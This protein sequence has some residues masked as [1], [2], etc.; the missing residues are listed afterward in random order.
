MA[1]SLLA[2]RDAIFLFERKRSTGK[3]HPFL[4]PLRG[5]PF[6]KGIL[7]TASGGKPPIEASPKPSPKGEGFKISAN[8]GKGK[9]TTC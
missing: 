2:D 7:T 8:R 4:Q 1:A 5:F 3:F 6:N 9:V